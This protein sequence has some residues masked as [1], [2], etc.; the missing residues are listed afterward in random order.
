MSLITIKVNEQ[1]GPA[2]V[3]VRTE[4][5]RLVELYLRWIA[6]AI[7]IPANVPMPPLKLNVRTTDDLEREIERWIAQVTA[8]IESKG[9]VAK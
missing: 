2:P 5:A 6:V 9:G 1:S 8:L 7:Q 4:T 3:V